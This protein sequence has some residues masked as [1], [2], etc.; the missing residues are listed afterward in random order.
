MKYEKRK[1]GKIILTGPPGAG[2]TTIEKVFFEMANPLKLLNYSLDPTRGIISRDFCYFNKEFTLFDLAGQENDKWFS[3]EKEV[4]NRSN[5]IIC[6]FDIRNSLEFI[7]QFLIK[8]FNLQKVLELKKCNIIVLL[9]KIDLVGL[10][11]VNLKVKKIKNFYELN[12]TNGRDFG[13]FS[14]SISKYFF[15]KTYNIIFDIINHIL[16]KVIIPKNLTEIKLLEID[17]SVLLN[18]KKKIY[19]EEQLSNQLNIKE[20]DL[21]IHLSKLEKIG[22]L[23]TLVDSTNFQLTDRA[24]FFKEGLKNELQSYDSPDFNIGIVSINKILN[25]NEKYIKV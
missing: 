20:S 9:H 12:Y 11:Y 15:F 18:C 25:L 13:I 8:V 5:I 17:L 21:K 2:K 6:I 23:K 3:D 24:F 19:D 1:H 22:F 16:K 10:S 14:T 4:F 7:I